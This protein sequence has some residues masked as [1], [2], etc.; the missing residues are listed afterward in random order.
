MKE[1]ELLAPVGSYESLVAAVQNGCD[2]VYLG[3]RAFGARAYATN[4]DKKT[5]EEAVDY[6]HIRG[7]KV[8]VTIN[9]LIKD[10]E[11]VD[12]LN[13]VLE[14]YTIGVDAVI[15]QDLGAVK[16]LQDNF[17]DLAIHGSTQMTLHNS[18][19]IKVLYE[20][21]IK[22]VVLARELNLQE[23]AHISKNTEVDLEI[24]IHG[25]LCYSYSGQCLM[26]S[27]IGGRSGN[28]GR[29]AQPC[30]KQYE[31]VSLKDN[32]KRSPAL[33][34]LSMRDLNTLEDV[35]KIIESGVKSFKIEGRM[36]RPQYVASIVK[37][38]RKGINNYLTHKKELIDEETMKEVTQIFNR[39]FTKG[40]ILN[41]DKNQIL[42]IEKPSNRGLFLGRADDYNSKRGSFTIKLMEDLNQGDGIEIY[43]RNKESV[44]G[45]INKLY[46]DNKLTHE[47]KSGSIVEIK[48][49]GRV[50]KGDNVYKTFDNQLTKSLE[51]TYQGVIE[52]KKIPIWGELKVELG[53]P[54]KL[55][56]WDAD[57]NTVYKDSEEIIEKARN[58]GLKEEKIIGNLSKL[59]NTPFYLEN[60]YIDLQEDVAISVASINKIRRDA[61]EDLIK[62]RKN[63][64]KRDA[65][66]INLYSSTR[67]K[68]LLATGLADNQIPKLMV[69]VD[70][71]QQLETV[72]HED[73]DRVYYGGI[74]DLHR[75]TKMC[76]E[77]NIEIFFK[78]PTILKDQESQILQRIL[79]KNMVDG[80][81]A[82]ELGFLNFA[83]NN[84]KTSV[85]ADAS[86]NIMNSST[87]DFL[88]D[89]NVN[90]ITLSTELDLKNIENLQINKDLEVEVIIYGKLPIMTTET[91]P[92]IGNNYCNNQCH[93]CEDKANHYTRGLK[94]SKNMVFP[95]TKDD[96][97]R[98]I[99]IN[100]N[101]LYMVDKIHDLFKLSIN[102]YRLEF[103]DEEPEEIIKIIRSHRNSI[104]KYFSMNNTEKGYKDI[105]MDIKDFTRGHFYRGVE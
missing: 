75:V 19:G 82:G 36:K 8:Y 59:G 44:G 40:Y 43:S 46:I 105:G 101:P 2:A 16:I 62:I 49:N 33:F 23:I 70:T 78:S 98:T 91:C 26:S 35:G 96:W 93:K 102:N 14:L 5:M 84:L 11:R 25:A 72:L 55:Y 60:I 17:K 4:F 69:K 87:V 71:I 81:L 53:M 74:H 39:K 47:A 86:F 104:E 28:R 97:G 12:F 37:S 9:T 7:V 6:A 76:K 41:S 15:V 27:F 38:Y 67:E 30:R 56:I 95:F 61:I 20:K 24:F 51:K 48:I 34:H 21:G 64:N 79:E 73:V 18:E 29:C 68:D 99:I 83:K 42:N 92:L 85:I 65:K 103:T 88:K 100:S 90:G 54:L 31:I 77:N 94:D 52:N 63:K 10:N 1:I 80:I 89:M 58:I 45:I 32:Q 57:G 3:G 66:T 13:Y 22:R 50:Q